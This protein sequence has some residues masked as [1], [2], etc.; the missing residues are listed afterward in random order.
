MIDTSIGRC[1]REPNCEY[2]HAKFCTI[3]RWNMTV[4]EFCVWIGSF[5][6]GS[7]FGT[8]PART[9]NYFNIYTNIHTTRTNGSSGLLNFYS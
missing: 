7:E 1:L 4:A 2:I 6:R 5:V 3:V 9:S 8:R